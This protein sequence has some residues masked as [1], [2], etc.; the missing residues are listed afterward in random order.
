MELIDPRSGDA[1]PTRKDNLKLVLL[2]TQLC[3][4]LNTSKPTRQFRL[5]NRVQCQ[6][7]CQILVISQIR[8][9]TTHTSHVTDKSEQTLLVIS[10]IRVITTYA[11]H[12]TD[13]SSKSTTVIVLLAVI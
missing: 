10:Q 5:Q 13:K 1:H 11:C 6:A 9:L 8:V 3:Y 7:Q 2:A 12:I 4:H